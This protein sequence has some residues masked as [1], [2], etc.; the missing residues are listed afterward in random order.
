M[1]HALSCY[2]SPMTQG[3]TSTHDSASE[4]TLSVKWQKFSFSK[5]VVGNHT[6]VRY[7]QGATGQVEDQLFLP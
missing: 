2:P 3:Q 5:A 7:H 4:L 1:A 6:G